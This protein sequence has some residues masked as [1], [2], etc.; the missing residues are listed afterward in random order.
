MITSK[1]TFTINKF[2]HYLQEIL[3]LNSCNNFKYVFK[4]VGVGLAYLGAYFFDPE[5]YKQVVIAVLVLPLFDYATGV[6]AAYSK[7]EKIQSR[8]FYG[9]IV[10]IVTYAIVVAACRLVE[11]PV[12][13]LGLIDN[14]A[15]KL[16]AVTEIWSLVENF[17]KMGYVKSKKL[18]ELIRGV[19]K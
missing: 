5:L 7:K 11:S 13:E 1:L 4:L 8:G 14:L 16:I 2:M 15:I 6:M 19:T 18:K 12:P 17:D 3:G 10:K 9:T